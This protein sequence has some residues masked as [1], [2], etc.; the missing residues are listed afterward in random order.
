[1]KT[2]QRGTATGPQSNRRAG[3][4]CEAKEPS[5]FNS[6]LHQAN[7][8]LLLARWFEVAKLMA[9]SY[10]NGDLRAEINR[11]MDNLRAM[12]SREIEET[13]KFLDSGDELDELME[14]LPRYSYGRLPADAMG[15][16]E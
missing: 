12:N 6:E 11:G 13:R 3:S 1:M 4:S 14:S 10:S 8:R 2:K 15:G 5:V 9:T 7:R 16:L